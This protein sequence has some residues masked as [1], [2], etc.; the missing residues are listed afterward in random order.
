MQA[1]DRIIV[2]VDV[3]HP[4]KA[5]ELV[6]KLGPKVGSFKIG[7]ELITAMLASVLVM[8]EQE[9]LANAKRVR[10]LF[11]LL[12][13]QFFYDGKFKD[14]PNTVGAVSKIVGKM[15]KVGMFNVHAS[16][17]IKGMMAAVE[18]KG[19]SK[20][21]AV[22]VLTSHEE[23]NAFLDYGA[24]SKAKVLQ[25]ARNAKLAGCDGVICSPQELMLLDD[26]PELAGL[27]K[28]TPG[29]RSSDDPADDQKRTLSPR[30]AT[31][32]GAT[33][34]VIGRPITKAASPVEAAQKIAGEIALGLVDRLHMSLFNLQKIK[35]GAFKL[36]LHEKHPDAPLSPIYLNIREL[37]EDWLYALMGD[38]LHDLVVREGIGDFDY[39]I[40]IPKA[41]EPIGKAFAK[42][43]GKPHLRI[44]K[45]E[46]EGGRRITSTILDPFEKG[47]KVVII[48]DLVTKADTKREAIKSVEANGLEVVA[49]IV[50]YDR[51][52]GGLKE[53]NAE[54]RKVC[55]VA[56]L[57]ETMEF[58]VTKKKIDAAKKKE[59]MEYIAAN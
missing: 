21:L 23:N 6:T 25:Y 2:A 3:D 10:E 55:A 11:Q 36:K 9:A 27:R 33:E 31:A 13:R 22:T 38:I 54:G 15:I 16:S 30:E 44:E 41:G 26:Q 34:L 8:D 12:G 59:V 40:G 48:D 1:K 45:V 57:S 4:D 19:E 53:L 18:N 37:P 42:A 39:V 29:I 28:V 51:E 46:D 24:P 7:L 58:F 32:A 5:I 47:K 52:Q 50:L 56:K 43:V 20:V 17:G 14:I 49:T 35:F